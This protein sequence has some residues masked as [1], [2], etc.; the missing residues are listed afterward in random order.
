MQ[1]Q[2]RPEDVPVGE[3]PRAVTLIADRQ[4]V[5]QV[6]PGTR[7]T[8]T[9]IYSIYQVCAPSSAKRVPSVTD[10]LACM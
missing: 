5:G 10:V 8:I 7:V 4:L 9:G 2:E 3:L 1:L 6:A